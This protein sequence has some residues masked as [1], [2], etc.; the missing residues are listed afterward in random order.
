M[1]NNINEMTITR[2]MMEIYIKHAFYSGMTYGYGVDHEK[3]HEDEERFWNE[4]W[5]NFNNIHAGK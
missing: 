1:A 4:F 5:N 2:E 3:I